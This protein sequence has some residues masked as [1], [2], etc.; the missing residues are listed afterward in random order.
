[1]PKYRIKIELDSKSPEQVKQVG[2]LIQYAVNNVEQD[3]LVLLLEKVQQNPGIVKS[4][5]GALNFIS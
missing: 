5:L 1:M 2:N 4:A 3:D